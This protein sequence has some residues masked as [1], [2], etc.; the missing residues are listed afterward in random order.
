MW[1][2]EELGERSSLGYSSS[3][4]SN[5]IQTYDGFTASDLTCGRLMRQGREAYLRPWR[6]YDCPPIPPVGLRN[7]PRPS[8]ITTEVTVTR[9]NFSSWWQN[10]S[11]RKHH[12]KDVNSCRD[13]SR[14]HGNQPPGRPGHVVLSTG[15]HLILATMSTDRACR[16]KCGDG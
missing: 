6:S 11:N 2:F 14:I 1:R 12:A 9:E 7:V 13:A 16:L 10:E 5:Q 3:S 4:I 15:S 8:R